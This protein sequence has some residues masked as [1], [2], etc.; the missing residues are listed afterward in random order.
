VLAAVAFALGAG[1]SLELWACGY[2]LA[3]GL[4]AVLA[5]TL[6]RPPVRLRWRPRLFR[7]RLRDALL[8]AFIQFTWDMQ[9]DIDKLV[10]ITLANDHAAGIYAIATR[11]I[12]MTTV[13]IKTFFVLYSRKLIREQRLDGMVRRNLL[14]EAAIAVV[15]FVAYAAFLQVMSWYP[16]LL[17]NNIETARQLFGAMLLVPVFRN[18][19][20]LHAELYFAYGAFVGRALMVVVLVLLK[21]GA[22]VAMVLSTAGMAQWGLWLNAIFAGLWLVSALGVYTTVAKPA[23]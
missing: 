4:S 13:P 8:F 5:L 22:L 17:G 14:V 21:A 11:V 19:I 20:D 7:V 1:R 18:L 9:K 12:E 2:A 3:N 16:G 10:L 6:F 15:S 23:R